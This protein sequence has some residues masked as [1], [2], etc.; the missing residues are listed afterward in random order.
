[1]RNGIKSPLAKETGASAVEQRS[2]CC[3]I[4][5]DKKAGWIGGKKI[6][7]IQPGSGK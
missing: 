2:I 3:R 7:G 6:D 5:V 4:L 1:M